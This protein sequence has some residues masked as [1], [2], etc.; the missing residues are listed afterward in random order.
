VFL[1][2]FAV[3]DIFARELLLYVCRTGTYIHHTH[4]AQSDNVYYAPIE[5]HFFRKG[6]VVFR[7]RKTGCSGCLNLSV[8]LWKNG[9]VQSSINEQ[10][11]VC[12]NALLRPKE[13]K[14][15]KDYIFILYTEKN[16][17]INLVYYTY[18]TY[19]VDR[20][21]PPQTMSKLTKS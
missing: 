5:A 2:E 20:L 14:C 17:K 1:S 12:C 19:R 8:A 6:H 15:K 21:Q 9:N 13:G 10:T 3:K 16:Y 11:I 4:Y 18:Y 7:V